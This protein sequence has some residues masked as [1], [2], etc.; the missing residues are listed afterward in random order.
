V[1][2]PLSQTKNLMV[3]CNIES[4]DGATIEMLNKKGYLVSDIYEV[5]PDFLKADEPAFLLKIKYLDTSKFTIKSFK[6]YIREEEGKPKNNDFAWQSANKMKVF[7]REAPYSYNWYFLPEKYDLT[8]NQQNY[9][10]NNRFGR[11]KIITLETNN[12]T[13]H[14]PNDVPYMVIVQEIEEKK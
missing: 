8:I 12:L 1:I 2:R 13:L 4:I 5:Y 10:T 7:I 9:T 11:D 14:C 6:K 3:A